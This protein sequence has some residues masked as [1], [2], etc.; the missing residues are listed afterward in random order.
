M[1]AQVTP[2]KQAASSFENL[3]MSDSPVKKLNF[4]AAGKENAPSS[5]QIIDVPA[6]KTTVEKPTE[7]SSKIAS[8]KEMEANEPLLQ[9]N[10]HRFVLFPIKYHE[11]WQMYK[12]AE[13]SFWTAEE[14]DLSKDLHDW[15]NRLNDDERFFI[16]RVLAFFA[17]S[18]GIVNENLLERFSGEVQIPEARCFYGF[19]IMIEN[20]HAETY[21]LLIDT[22]IKEPKQRTYLFDAIDTIPCIRK[23]A[24]WAIRWI[25]DQES[26]FGQRLVAFAAVEG[27]FFSGSFASIFWLKKRGL[28]PGLTF[29]N[30]LISRDEGLHT[31]FA[32]LLFSHLNN[33]PDPQIVEDV[34]VEAVSIEKE[35]LTDAL[36]CALLGMNS[37]L[38]C[39]YIEFV[40]DRLLVALGN[41]KYFNATNPFDFMDNISLAGKTNFF[42]KRVGDYQKAGVMASTKKEAKQEESSGSAGGLSFDEDF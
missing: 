24:D 14:I 20:I 33:R 41:N 9:E 6:T 7:V 37:N 27:I 16:S 21:S 12:K 17:A 3:K 32:C 25:Q 36:P 31:D 34:I 30:E 39:Q 23:K 19:Q 11:I 5:L 26:T 13:A 22:Y 40:A 1:S 15:H 28:M 8:I 38:M 35:F 10:P 18:D 42:E 2:S 4:E 29:S